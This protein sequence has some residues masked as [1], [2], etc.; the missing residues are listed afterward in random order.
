MKLISFYRINK[1]GLVNFWRHG[2]LSLLASFILTLTL[3][4][5]TI[6]TVVNITIAVS[7]KSL[8]DK[9][10]LSV[11]FKEDTT[12]EEI[13][14]LISV[15][16][17]RLDI[18]S[19]DYVSKEKAL[20]RWQ[21]LQI[22]QNIKNQISLDEN[23]LPR[24]LEIKPKDPDNL[25]GIVTFLTKSD[26]DNK[27]SEISYQQNKDIIEKI[28][29]FTKFSRRLG[30][31]L[32]ILFASI[33]IIVIFNTMKLAIYT[34]Q[35]EIEIMRLVGANNNFI[36]YPFLI[37]SL[38]ISIIAT[39]LS[40]LFIWLGLLYISK[41]I[42]HFIGSEINFSLFNFFHQYILLI[43]LLQFVLAIFITI[44]CTFF[45]LRKHLKI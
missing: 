45:S 32:S 43:I 25:N 1:F 6:F 15:L 12:Q 36:N 8:E 29:N 21:Q 16:S 33:A 2:W 40:T 23:P 19:L 26:F 13:D 20:E 35:E 9:I 39:F 4:T 44:I 11:Y 17:K 38:L 34:R 22:K 27:I 10:N 3:L 14:S 28:T 31:V 24:S 5:I 30:L 37:E 41:T 7:T 18:V 42:I